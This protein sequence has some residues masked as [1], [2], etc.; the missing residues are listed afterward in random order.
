MRVRG[1]PGER[2][3]PGIVIILPVIR[4][5]RYDDTPSG[6]IESG[7]GGGARRRRRRRNTR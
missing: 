6:D 2:R 4:V 5:E 3:E 1:A 7:T